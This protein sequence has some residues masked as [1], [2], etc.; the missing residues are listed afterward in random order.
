LNACTISE[1]SNMTAD[2]KCKLALPTIQA[3]RS[4]WTIEI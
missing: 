2:G 1:K 4:F 3:S